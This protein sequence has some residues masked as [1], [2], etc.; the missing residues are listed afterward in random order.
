MIICPARLT[1]LL[2]IKFSIDI[3]TA[4]AVIDMQTLIGVNE[5]V[6]MAKQ[7]RV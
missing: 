4:I 2:K 3:L 1:F 5:G 6:H 7:R